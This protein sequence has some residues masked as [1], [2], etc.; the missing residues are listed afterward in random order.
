[1]ENKSETTLNP[2]ETSATLDSEEILASIVEQLSNL[3]SVVTRLGCENNN[4]KDEII[5]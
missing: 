4:R 2:P 3:N 5:R 1:M